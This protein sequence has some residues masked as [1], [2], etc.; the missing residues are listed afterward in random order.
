MCRIAQRG[1]TLVEL[2]IVVVI[3]GILAAIA[4]PNMVQM[5]GRAREGALKANM[6]TIQIA[7]EDYSVQN[8][9][10]YAVAAADVVALLSL[11]P[12]NFK[13]PFTQGTAL[14]DAWEDRGSVLNPPSSVS[15]ITSYADSLGIDYNVKGYG[16]N[17][18]LSLVLSTGQ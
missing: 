2:M 1:F 11:G 17:G 7:A 9:G 8:D 10:R 16:L 6:H 3:I 5:R 13:N 4:I 15:G 14:G 18:A 12:S